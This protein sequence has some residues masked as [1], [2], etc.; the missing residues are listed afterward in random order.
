MNISIIGG[1]LRIIKLAEMYAEEN[2][3]VYT[4][5]LEK[6]FE[7]NTNNKNIILCKNLKEAITNSKYIISSIP[8]TKDKINI[9]LAGRTDA[10]V[11]AKSQVAH[12]DLKEKTDI[13]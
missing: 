13:K 11:S 9:T 8:F 10:K 2:N 4:Y 12:F 3:V 6:Y 7:N 5:G 1:D